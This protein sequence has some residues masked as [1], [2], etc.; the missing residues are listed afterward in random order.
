MPFTTTFASLS[1]KGFSS[2]LPI[3]I[4]Y[5]LE[6]TELVATSLIDGGVAI[7][8]DQADAIILGDSSF[9]SSVGTGLTQ[10]GRV[11]IEGMAGNTL[12]SFSTATAVETGT[13]ALEGLGETTFIDKNGTYAVASPS[14]PSTASGVDD[15][16]IYYAPTA[17]NWSLQTLIGPTGTYD[18]FGMHGQINQNGDVV[19]AQGKAGGGGSPLVRTLEI[20][21]RTGV[22]TW[23]F[24]Q[25]ITD[26]GDNTAF[27]DASDFNTAG[28][29]LIAGAYAVDGTT[30]TN[31]GRAYIYEKSGGT[32]SLTATLQS[33]V[34]PAQNDESFGIQV[35]MNTTGDS[36]VISALKAF[37][38]GAAFRFEKS[39]GTW[40][41]TTT[42]Q[43]VDDLDGQTLQ[44][45]GVSMKANKDDHNIIIM[46]GQVPLAGA[47]GQG[48][49]FIGQLG[50]GIYV[51]SQT[52]P[53]ASS[54]SMRPMSFT[55][56][57]SKFIGKSFVGGNTDLVL[58]AKA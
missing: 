4:D 50:S 49:V 16:H 58:Y 35:Q 20:S 14:L 43:P 6:D 5:V 15:L 56:D 51:Q 26:G 52:I 23:S 12:P 25:A 53:F 3:F 38:T 1:S 40:S 42:F 54:G 28:D 24:D 46:H 7:A 57:G 30:Y 11:F 41:H 9:S 13:V 47:Y 36:V 33:P 34:T 27:G 21:S 45:S 48:R 29:A 55:N 37:G 19:L 22:S 10:N 32:W 8:G 44:A 39:G 31:E 18:A 2:D 17:N